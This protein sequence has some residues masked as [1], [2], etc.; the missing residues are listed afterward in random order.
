MQNL[1]SRQLKYIIFELSENNQQ[2]NARELSGN[3]KYFNTYF[4]DSFPGFALYCGQDN[5]VRC[6]RIYIIY[7]LF[8]QC[9]EKIDGVWNWVATSGCIKSKKDQKIVN[10][11]IQKLKPSIS[12]SFDIITGVYPQERLKD[13]GKEYGIKDLESGFEP[14]DNILKAHG[15]DV[16]AGKSKTPAG[17]G[18]TPSGGGNMPSGD[19]I[20][21]T[22]GGN[23]PAGG[24]N[25]PA[26][27]G[28]TPRQKM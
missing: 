5:N 12:S 13:V 17:G 1:V 23:T 2:I 22:N 16:D 20:I 14:S 15:V 3:D 11:I 18:N 10:C 8:H 6:Q 19:G 21:P 9:E 24:G 27:D 25:T 26:G 28:I 4:Y 7:N